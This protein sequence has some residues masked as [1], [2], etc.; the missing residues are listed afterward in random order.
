L[1]YFCGFENGP[2]DLIVTGASA[3]IAGEAVAHIRFGWVVVSIKQGFG[4]DQKSRRADT[5][6]QTRVLEEFL[7][8]RMEPRRIAEALDGGDIAILR[9]DA[10]H[11]TGAGHPAIDDD[12]AGAAVA[13]QTSFLT[14]GHV[15]GV[16]QNF[17][18]AL[19]RFAE[20]LYRFAIYSRFDNGL[21]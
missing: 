10:E 15:Q 18:Q 4:R 19:T 5:A 8:Q 1:H 14:A 16:P 17:E 2:D 7:L 12:A 11:Q 9:L 13:G 20:K 21:F 6:L 3:Q